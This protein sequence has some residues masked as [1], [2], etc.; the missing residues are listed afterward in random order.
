MG[1]T[2]C[3]TLDTF[4]GP[5]GL[6]DIEI[7]KPLPL[8]PDFDR[9][10]AMMPLARIP[11]DPPMPPAPSTAPSTEPHKQVLRHM[12]EAR[13]L[14]T[15]QRFSE[16]I[17]ELEK[18]L[19]YETG[20]YEPYR[21]IAVARALLGNETSARFYAQR[22]LAL[23]PDDLTCHFLLAWLADREQKTEDALRGYRLAL[24]CPDD[25]PVYRVLTHYYLGLLLD[26]EGY[27]AAAIAQLRAFDAGVETLGERVKEN[28]DLATI[29]RVH[30]VS[31]I[32]RMARAQDLLEQYA[33]AAEGLERAVN[34]M[35]DDASL[36][37]GL[38]RRLVLA[39]RIDEAI[40][41]ARRFMQDSNGSAEAVKLLLAVYY[42]LG[43]PRE[44]LREVKQLLV[45]RPEDLQLALIYTEALIA[46]HEYDQAIAELETWA[47]RFPEEATIRWRL[48]EAYRIRGRWSP[49][50]N[51][52]VNALAEEPTDDSAIEQALDRLTLEQAEK[53]I[54][55]AGK[56]PTSREEPNQDA[57]LDYLLGGLCDRLD[58]V[59]GAREHF[60]RARR[61][62]PDYLPAAIG[63]AR[64]D[65]RRCRW[66]EA[67]DTIKAAEQNLAQP[68]HR[69]HT[70]LG[71]CHEGLDQ[72]EQAV[73]AYEK[74]IQLKPADTQAM[75]LLGR[76][77]ERIGVMSKARQCYQS[78]V[79]VDP[80]NLL[81]REA[82][83]QS[84]MNQLQGFLRPEERNEAQKRLLTELKELET[85]GPRAPS[86][87]RTSALFRYLFLS[88]Q[89][90]DRQEWYIQNLA[91]VADDFPADLRTHELL[92]T[93]LFAFR[94]YPDAA[95]RVAEMLQRDPYSAT[96]NELHYLL[97]IRD[98]R[99][100][101]ALEHLRK[102]LQWY[103]NRTAWIQTL[104]NLYLLDRRYDDAIA[105][106]ERLLSLEGVEERRIIFHGQL[107]RVY[108]LARR[109]EEARERINGW[110]AGAGKNRR[111][112]YMLRLCLIDLAAEDYAR[113]IENCRRWLAD[114][115]DD[116]DLHSWL[117]LALRQAGRFDE[118]ALAALSRL[119]AQPND[120]FLVDGLVQVLIA[121]HR[122]DEAI[123]LLVNQLA[124]SDKLENQLMTLDQL[125]NAYIQAGRY[126]E[127]IATAGDLIA[128]DQRAYEEKLELY[129]KLGG[130]HTRAGRF[131]EAV[132]HYHSMLRQAQSEEEKAQLL[133]RIAFVH[134]RQGRLDLTLAR[135]REAHD[136]APSD[137]G[138]NNDLGYT[139]ADLGTD[140]DEAERMT[141]LAVGEEFMQPAYLDSLGWVMYK[142][143]RLA[144]AR[145]W[146]ERASALENGEDPV[147]FDHL[148]DVYWRLGERERARETW[149]KSLQIQT[150]QRADMD[151]EVNEE[152]FAAIQAKLEAVRQGGSPQV[153]TMPA[154]GE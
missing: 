50:L 153:A 90:E 108:Q 75:F 73:A 16:T 39:D 1:L 72:L 149:Q 70:L 94:A 147:I 25:D 68:D 15:E 71:Q 139:L 26:R 36:R 126:A 41:Q 123:E 77:F 51:I 27:Y 62:R 86:T 79:T 85:R 102:I 133:R 154:A 13:R 31:T 61:T 64:L 58:R 83:A 22:A 99:F 8:P 114:D 7:F 11:G 98:L 148:G 43:R 144:D 21:L 117:L 92:A 9:T 95:A 96:A 23:K 101:E 119:S 80:E 67:I 132:N 131:D 111:K 134:Q 110:M 28:P 48:A 87:R 3:A 78:V 6:D 121:A 53:I 109:F 142:K 137:I 143:G 136:L 115:P 40:R 33:E 76:L 118:A 69:L 103:P 52:M 97:L 34:K 35:P 37:I 14:F 129:E 125:V 18:A 84:Y 91:Q 45:G 105:L 10:R 151:A 49:W 65:I 55:Q 130:I 60:H 141:K 63:E 30:R 47:G 82:L 32:V 93:T 145:L 135:L 38:V 120:S 140:L 128:R 2:G 81:A 100:A 89:N 54:E 44:G 66:S 19:R 42:H 20:Y 88:S 116:P 124:A 12:Q 113:C 56:D 146:L 24:K 17:S 150:E 104:A 29:V 107:L 138:I 5:G 4:S 122:H 59:E 112:G 152:A 106:W 57:A 74:A 46:A 127:A